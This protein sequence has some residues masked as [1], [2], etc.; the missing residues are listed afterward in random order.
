LGKR[1][2]GENSTT[3]GNSLP[4]TQMVVFILRQLNQCFKLYRMRKE[5]KTK[6]LH[7]HG[8]LDT[9]NLLRRKYNKERQQFCSKTDIKIY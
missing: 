8:W 6:K 3:A 1:W 9:E 2:N 7:Q 5:Y 4:V